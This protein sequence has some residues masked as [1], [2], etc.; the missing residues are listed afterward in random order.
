[1]KPAPLTCH[2]GNPKPTRGPAHGAP[3]DFAA[4]RLFRLAPAPLPSPALLSEER[5]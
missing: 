5:S 3:S 2:G 1:M 4:A